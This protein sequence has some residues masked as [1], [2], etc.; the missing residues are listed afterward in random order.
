MI[1]NKIISMILLVVMLVTAILPIFQTKVKAADTVV[2]YQGSVTYGES[3]VGKF[4][5]NRKIAFCLEHQKTTPPSGRPLTS[6]IYSDSNILKCLFYGWEGEKQWHFASEE[7][8]IVYT[9]LALDHFKNGN[10]NRTA[11][12][13]IDYVNSQP[14]PG[15]N[16]NFKNN[17]EKAY[18]ENGVQRTPTNQVYGEPELY[19]TI[20]L[21]EG[22]VLVNETKGTRSTGD[23]NVYGEDE[24]HL[25]APM[26]ISGSWKSDPI[27]NHK[28]AYQAIVYKTES[29]TEQDLV[30]RYGFVANTDAYI[31]L[32]VNWLSTGTLEIYKKD[33][34]TKETISNTTFEIKDEEGT[35][36]ETITTNENGY[37]KSSDLVAGVYTLVEKSA[38]DKYIKN[39]TPKQITISA[40]ETIT[41]DI[42]NKHKQGS[43]KI[44][45]VDSRD[46]KMPIPNVTF[47][48]WNEELNKK[49]ATKTT[50]EDGIITL[51]NLRTGTKINRSKNR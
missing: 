5:V 23:V 9:T 19:M 43:L 11:Q 35:V 44:V 15:G 14:V 30:S 26:S 40:G 18:I 49:V 22:M 10:A 27:R 37:A 51:D 2:D 36:V 33:E 39:S 38:N 7:Q 12:E 4:F 50:G 48:I 24:F 28:Y 34:E 25:E 32:Y 16:L 45:K 46:G 13:F 29:K 8:G 31:R 42:T 21:P 17:N 41:I 1:R 47:E 6:E 3:T 20:H